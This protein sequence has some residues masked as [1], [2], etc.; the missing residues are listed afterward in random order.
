[1][2]R[3]STCLQEEQV[4]FRKGYSTI[5]QIFNLF[6]MSHKYLYKKDGFYAGFIDFSHAFDGI[7]HNLLFHQLMKS[8]IH[9]QILRLI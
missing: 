5:D 9:G 2:N 1:V 6:I 8:G 4:G 7:R 3:K